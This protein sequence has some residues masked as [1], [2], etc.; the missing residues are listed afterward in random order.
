M[1]PSTPST[2]WRKEG[3]RELLVLENERVQIIAWPAM[4]GALC[5]FKDRQSG[6][7][8][9]WHNPVLENPGCHLYAQPVTDRTDLYD[10]LDGSWFVSLPTGFMPTNY[11]GAPIGAH[12][13]LRAVPWKVTSI[14]Q[15]Q[16]AL[17]VSLHGN[18][19]RTPFRIERRWILQAD[20]RCLIWEE[21]VVNRSGVDRPLFWM[22]HPSF[23]G[24]L[25]NGAELHID[26]RKVGVYGGLDPNQVQV[27]PGYQG[28]WPHIPETPRGGGEIRDCS[29][30]A[31]AGSGKEH[32]IMLTEFERGWGCVWNPG[33]GL[34]FGLRWDESFFP[35]AW[36]WMEAGGL[37]DY[38]LWGE[39]HLV[40]IQPG[41]SPVAPFPDL[42]ESGDVLQVPAYGKLSTRF[43]CGFVE[44]P[45]TPWGLPEK[46]KVLL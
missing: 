23:G 46:G 8:A 35:Y 15:E 13:E 31:P 22:H 28:Q 34:G 3:N 24:P 5:T 27:Q 25:V 18:S 19:V 39:G 1:N 11:Y 9:L 12:G 44:D 14:T 2:S 7:D 40:T 26:C 37:Q 30:V 36:S 17:V 4:G 45:E 21:T 41:T 29:R 6:L 38:P 20:S 33:L 42:V 43:I 16:G 10:T 32:S